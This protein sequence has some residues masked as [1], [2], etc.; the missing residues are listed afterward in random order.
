MTQSE[1]TQE[2][3]I[4][5]ALLSW[6]FP[7]VAAFGSLHWPFTERMVRACDVLEV[8]PHLIP[9]AIFLTAMRGTATNLV[10]PG[11]WTHV[12]MYVGNQEIT[13]AVVHP[14]VRR[15]TLPDLLTTKDYAILLW[16]R[17]A[18]RMQMA[19]AAEWAKRQ[20]GKPYDREM[21][22]DLK[23][24]SR[25]ELGGDAYVY[26]MGGLTCPFQ[27]R[28]RFGEPIFTPQDFFDAK[29]KWMMVW[30]SRSCFDSHCFLHNDIALR[31]PPGAAASA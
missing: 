10:I 25:S 21:A 8:G 28:D 13:E 1:V 2:A 23:A 11:F 31:L 17:F 6:A 19:T 29:D 12:A 26:T 30:A 3:R 22:S 24:F 27:A 4:K 5:R 7:A 18:D 15:S 9:G 14:G 16:P 20:E